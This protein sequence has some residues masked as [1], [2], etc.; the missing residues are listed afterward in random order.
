M[1]PRPYHGRLLDQA[2][3]QYMRDKALLENALID[4]KRYQEAYASNAIPK[5]QLDTQ[6]AQ[7]HQDEGTVRLDEGQLTNAPR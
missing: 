1:S 6:V 2:Q 7:V 5:Q 3:G 4:L